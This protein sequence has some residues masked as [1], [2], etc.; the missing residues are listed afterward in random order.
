GEHGAYAS[1]N[2]YLDGL[3]ENRRARGLAATSVVW[4]IWDPEDGGGMAANL[5]KEQLLGRGIP[6]M[7]PAMALSALQQVLDHH[8]TVVLAAAV[9][10]DR[11]APVFTSVRPSPLM[12]DLP[13]VSRIRS[14]QTAP[15]ADDGEAGSSLR[16][17]LREAAPTER[18]RLLVD[19][20][21][22]QAAS[23]LGHDSPSAVDPDRAF[24]ELGFDSL[25]AV[26][27]RNRLNTATGLRLPPTV[28]FDYSSAAAL[29][30]HVR[31]ELLGAQATAPVPV[32]L[33]AHLP[34]DDDPIAIVAM[35]CRYPG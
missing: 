19:L 18:D 30:R 10:W 29:A 20:V 22:A 27:I 31:D 34:T 24:R 23:V 17:R 12:A 32:D 1:A 13:E 8:Q 35:S 7:S 21:R 3:A 5:V 15:A 2:A 9:D 6:F 25:T 28:I 33:S 16:R 14:A 4:G 11:F 26:E